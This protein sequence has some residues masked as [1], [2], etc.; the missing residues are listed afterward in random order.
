MPNI[1]TYNSGSTAQP[2]NMP[3]IPGDFGQEGPEALAGASKQLSNVGFVLDY[4]LKQLKQVEDLARFGVESEEKLL[5]LHNS[6]LTDQSFYSDPEGARNRFKQSAMELKNGYLEQIKDAEVRTKWQAQFDRNVLDRQSHILNEARSFRIKSGA[7]TAEQV[8]NKYGGLISSAKTERDFDRYIYQGV[9]V[10]DGT[11]MGQGYSPEHG[12]DRKIRYVT[13][14][15]RQYAVQQITEDPAAALEAMEAGKGPYKYF[16]PGNN[17]GVVADP[18]LKNSL[19]LMAERQLEHRITQTRL[20]T[21]RME[22]QVKQENINRVYDEIKRLY[23]NE[24]KKRLEI[25]DD[26]RMYSRELPDPDDRERLKNM[27][28]ADV[29]EWEKRFD[30]ERKIA[31]DS[32]NAKYT[33]E[34]LNGRAM[35]EVEIDSLSGA[36]DDD[37]R[38]M[39]DLTLRFRKDQED[40]AEKAEKRKY[41]TDPRVHYEVLSRI[42][43][44]DPDVRITSMTGVLPYILN[45][46]SVEDAKQLEGAIERASDLNNSGYFRLAREHFDITFEDDLENKAQ[47]AEYMMRLD[48]DVKEEGLTGPAILQRAKELIQADRKKAVFDF[49]VPGSKQHTMPRFLKDQEKPFVDIPKTTSIDEGRKAALVKM[50]KKQGKATDDAAVV[51]LDGQLRKLGK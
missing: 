46:L 9:S 24:P 39:R 13:D 12:I 6:I 49:L 43:S 11:T 26:V 3:R 2:V 28:R 15:V 23:P 36:T 29:S 34:L 48:R 10:I 25:L 35:S 17:L 18:D 45:G 1:P 7:A 14:S 16:L 20:E 22:K 4:K 30:D 27:M 47:V 31:S 42:Y 40:R 21:D 5:E 8:L 38:Q 37:R 32:A 41:A 51:E 50:L 33:K 19:M 44:K